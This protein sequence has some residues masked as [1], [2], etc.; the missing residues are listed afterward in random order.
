[1]EWVHK[2]RGTYTGPS[3]AK[4]FEFSGIAWR[5]RNHSMDMLQHMLVG[6]GLLGLCLV[7]LRTRICIESYL[8]YVSV[9]S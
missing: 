6:M 2:E 3:R 7:C 8:H 9:W 5:S 1:M 4:G